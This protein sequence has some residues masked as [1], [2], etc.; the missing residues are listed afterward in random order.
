MNKYGIFISYRRFYTSFA[1]RI[2]DYLKHKGFAPFMD[3]YEMRQGY[4]PDE[5]KKQ[6]IECPY[7]LLVLSKGCFLTR[8]EQDDKKNFFIDEIKNALENKPRDNI[9]VVCEEGFDFYRESLPKG[10]DKLDMQQCDSLGYRTFAED[11]GKLVS[12]NIDVKVLSGFVDWRER[13][14]SNGSTLV[15]SRTLIENGHATLENRFGRELVEAVREHRQ[16]EGNSI[17]RQIR[18]SCYAA[19][20]V[21]TPFVEMIDDKAYDRGMLFNTFAE[22]LRDP[23]FSLEIII[24]APDS[25]AAQEAIRNDMLGN[26]RLEEHPE[27]VFYSAYANLMRL[28]TEDEIFRRANEEKRFR[29]YLSNTFMVGAIFQIGYKDGYEE[30]DHIKFDLYTYELTASMDRRCMVF[31][32]KDD[33]ETYEHLKK[34][35]EY[36]KKHGRGI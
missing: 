32:R 11:L 14:L 12:K 22:L 13:L 5:I 9:L 27:A 8:S 35:Y 29:Y 3:I 4:F 30:F 24:N 28:V 1:G 18:M 16:F 7:F 6:I 21:F 33:S 34:C 25:I 36:I 2:Y 15:G 31:F 23:E 19:N 26:S 20:L 10:I 17:V